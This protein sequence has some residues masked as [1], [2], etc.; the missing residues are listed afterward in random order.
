MF[1]LHEDGSQSGDGRR[2]LLE[3]GLW[4]AIHVI[5]VDLLFG[6]SRNISFLMAYC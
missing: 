6:C 2:G 4:D 5:E 1:L 3:H